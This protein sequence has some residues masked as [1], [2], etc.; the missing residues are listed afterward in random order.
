[1]AYPTPNPYPN[2][3]QPVWLPLPL[4]LTLSLAATRMQAVAC[5]SL[6]S[7]EELWL[8]DNP[9][10]EEAHLADLALLPRLQTLYLASSIPPPTTRTPPPTPARPTP[11]PP[12]PP[13]T[14]PAPLGPPA[15]GIAHQ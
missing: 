7:L 4:P 1:V 8:N 10:A 13:L 15:G 6:A 9:V 12:H 3:L 14:P 11:T 2:R 5:A